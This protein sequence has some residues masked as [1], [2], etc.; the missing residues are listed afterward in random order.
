MDWRAIPEEYKYELMSHEQNKDG[1]VLSMKVHEVLIDAY[2]PDIHSSLYNVF[3]PPANHTN[4]SPTY[5]QVR[6]RFLERNVV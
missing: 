2:N 3:K 6:L 4:L 5:L 1:P